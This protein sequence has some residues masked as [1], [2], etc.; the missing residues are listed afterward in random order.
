MIFP[1]PFSQQPSF[2]RD[3]YIKV[4]L[5][6]AFL[7][8]VL[9]PAHKCKAIEKSRPKSM[10]GDYII[11]FNSSLI[12]K[13]EKPVFEVGV[14]FERFIE[15]SNHHFSY[16]FAAEFEQ[17]KYLS[18]YFVGPMISAYYF[19]FKIFLASG[20]LTDF[21]GMNLWKSRL[22]IGYEF[23]WSSHWLV[24]PTVALDYVD[25]EFNPAIVLGLACEF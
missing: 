10:S 16:G 11:E 12:F 23:A 13:K 6:F 15:G 2:V 9:A 22:G 3:L 20:I 14:D 7:L 19:H 4:I 5:L 24:V 25:S 1:E 8:F 18:E 21:D 17:T